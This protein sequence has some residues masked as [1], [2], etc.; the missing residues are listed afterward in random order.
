[1][2]L[3][4]RGWGMWES[5]LGFIAVI[6][7]WLALAFEALTG[8]RV[9]G[10][11]RKWL[12][13]AVWLIGGVSGVL[14]IYL[15]FRGGG[16]SK[17][18]VTA[19]QGDIAALKQEMLAALQAKDA[20]GG[21]TPSPEGSASMARDLDAAIDTVLA[22]GHTEVLQ[23]KSGAALE[24]AIDNLIAQRAAARE[25]VAKDEAA[26]WRQKGALAFLHD[27]QSAL[28]AYRKA[29]ELD[30]DDAEGWNNLG[31]LL[32]RVGE[33]DRAIEAYERVLALG[34]RSSNKAVTAVAS[35]NLGTL[36]QTRGELDQAEQMY[37]KSLDLNEALGRK[38][39]MANQYGN[40]G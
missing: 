29:A 33:I 36:F 24:A 28:S 21:S 25:R 34:N 30:P 39:G 4:G 15:A 2:E 5:V 23:D 27:T 18:D 1:M 31:R 8:W 9:E 14:T 7:D 20:A 12:D 19:L 40:L 10:E 35:G 13:A 6:G 38:E 16:A 37:R 26:L 22:A 3:Q 17:E 32:H 11:S